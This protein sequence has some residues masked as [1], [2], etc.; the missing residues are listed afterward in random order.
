MLG[1]LVH[2]AQHGLAPG[3]APWARL[4]AEGSRG[5]LVSSN[6]THIVSTWTPDEPP[7]YVRRGTPELFAVEQVIHELCHARTFRIDPFL[8]VGRRLSTAIDR[9]F[10]SLPSDYLS[11]VYE[12]ETIALEMVVVGKLGM[13]LDVEALGY[14]VNWRSEPFADGAAWK[15][16]LRKLMARPSTA[17]MARSVLHWIRRAP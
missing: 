3:A 4:L 1:G 5:V 10:K 8:F 6:L 7:S 13:R 17:V 14:D 12:L 9:R 11:D 16:S 15:R 2:E